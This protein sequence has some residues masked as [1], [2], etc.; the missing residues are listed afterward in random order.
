MSDQP[1]VAEVDVAIV[2][3]GAAG[4]VLAA[5]LSEQ[6]DRTVALIEAGPDYP[7]PETL[8]EDLRSGWRSSGSHDWGLADE[9]T[10]KPHGR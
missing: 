7:D 3:G 6:P 1:A 9:Q 8:P 10:G 4:C 5:R 2:G